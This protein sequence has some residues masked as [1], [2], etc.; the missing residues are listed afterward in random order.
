MKAVII[1]YN[2]GNIRSVENALK[3]LGIEPVITANKQQIC[4][5]DKVIFPGWERLLPP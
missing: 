2:A 3:R 5:A 1:D 4:Q